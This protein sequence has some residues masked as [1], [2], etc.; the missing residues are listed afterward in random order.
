MSDLNT[1]NLDIEVGVAE[2]EYEAPSNSFRPVDPG[3]YILVRDP[4]SELDWKE[5]KDGNIGTK[6]TFLIQG[7]DFNGRKIFGYLSTTVG[8]FRSSSN[9]QDYLKACGYDEAPENGRR[10]TAREIIAAV[11]TTFGPF[12]AY[13]SWE[14]YCRNC[15]TTVIRK[16]S[17]FPR[18]ADGSLNHEASCPECGQTVVAHARIK[19]YIIG[20]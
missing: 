13:I 2:D 16:A 1:L 19:R 3:E 10:F 20:Q 8:R 9:I 17:A 7:G 18:N 12:E 6:V 4:E 15:D 14:G 11:E 5:I